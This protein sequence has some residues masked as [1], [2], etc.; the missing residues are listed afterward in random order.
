MF[1]WHP[2]KASY[3]GFSSTI[4]ITKEFEMF[5]KCLT[6]QLWNMSQTIGN[7]STRVYSIMKALCL[8]KLCKYLINIKIARIKLEWLL[9][10]GSR[11][12]N[13]IKI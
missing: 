7:H 2:P 12:G 3:H 6:L 8:V 1:F 10:Y 13:Q 11:H 5:E 4:S 9:Q